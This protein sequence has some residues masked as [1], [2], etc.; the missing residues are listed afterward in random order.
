MGHGC[1][2]RNTLKHLA[3]NG[4]VPAGVLTS[5][6][7]QDGHIVLVQAQLE[8]FTPLESGRYQCINRDFHNI[9]H[10]VLGHLR[11]L[12]LPSSVCPIYAQPILAARPSGQIFNRSFMTA[13]KNQIRGPG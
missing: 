1:L 10:H 2:L 9:P 7:C 13:R 3:S 5:T 11:F 6:H 12:R 4:R 8:C